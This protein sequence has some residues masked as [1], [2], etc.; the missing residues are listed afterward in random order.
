[1]LW[2]DKCQGK[3]LKILPSRAKIHFFSQ[4]LAGCRG[5]EG[6]LLWLLEVAC[7]SAERL[8]F[9]SCQMSRK[10]CY[11]CLKNPDLGNLGNWEQTL[12][13]GS[14]VLFLWITLLR[15]ARLASSS[16]ATCSLW[17]WEQWWASRVHSL[18]LSPRLISNTVDPTIN[19]GTCDNSKDLSRNQRQRSGGIDCESWGKLLKINIVFLRRHSSICIQIFKNN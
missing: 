12:Q 3:I 1:M 18:S 7:L 5:R 19:C 14:P 6:L 13:R 2:A 11:L 4:C 17:S 8:Y 15:W 9:S 10:Q 16:L